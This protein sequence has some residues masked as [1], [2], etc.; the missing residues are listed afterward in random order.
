MSSPKTRLS[1]LANHFLHPG[2]S[3]QQQNKSIDDLTIDGHTVGTPSWFNNH[4]LSPAFFLP[5]A[6]AIE[7]NAPAIYHRTANDKIL[8]RTYIEFADRARGFAYYIKKKGYK[9]VGILCTNTPAFLE[10]VFGIGAAGAIN[11]AINYRLKKDDIA[12]IFDHADADAIVV[13]AE[14]VDL[15]DD[16]KVNHPNVPL[17]VDT[18]TDAIQG[19]L[20][21]PFDEAVLEGLQYDTSRGSHGWDALETQAADELAVTALAYTSGTTARPKGVEYTHRG[22]YLA[23]LANVIESGLSY[24]DGERCKYLWTLPMFHAMG[25]TYPWAVTAVRGTHYCLRKIDYP[26]I[27]RLLKD[28]G[29]TH[30]CS[31]PTVNTLLCA[32]SNAVRLPKPVRVT[33]AASPPTAHLFEQMT[34]LNLHPVHVYGLTET[35]G[36]IT[37]GYI[38]PE[39]NDFANVKDKYAKMARQGHGIVT[40]LPVRVIKT[41]LPE[42]TILDVEKNG[43]EIGEIAFAGNICARGYYKD[44]AAT[45]KLFAGGVLHSG[46]LAVWHPDGAIQILDRAKD[47]IISGGENIS[48]VA[49]ESIFVTH[50]EILECGVAAVSDSHWGERPKA[51]ITVK[52]GSS[53]TG[54]DVIKWAKDHPG[55]SRFMVPREV[56]IVPELPKT[57]TGKIRKNVLRDW[58]KGKREE[59]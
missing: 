29:I 5:R 24:H 12:Y 54:D 40:S 10:A 17:I 37:K 53:V 36:P 43:K 50:P 6:A 20:C 13:D 19:Q 39:W 2:S 11:I 9:R 3:S 22:G 15:L 4:A 30:Y 23:A 14:F 57:S 42:G 46:D 58:A 16:Y 34:N 25:W 49:L 52:P 31:A 1:N 44:E 35:Y 38:L 47:I 8:R 28:E 59:E 7:P 48:S 18:D 26:E 27:W 32:D 41:D 21:G 45:R 33:V 51:F 56:E 55:I